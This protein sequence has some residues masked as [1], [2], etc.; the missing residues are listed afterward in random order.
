MSI[1]SGGYAQPSGTLKAL[2]DWALYGPRDPQITM[3]V[4][5]LVT[6]HGMTIEE[7]EALIKGSLEDAASDTNLEADRL[8]RP[9]PPE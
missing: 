7:V 8:K 6:K 9:D 1:A 2:V 3:L 5:R 4:S